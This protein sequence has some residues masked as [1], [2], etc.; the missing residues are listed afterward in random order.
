[1]MSISRW[2]EA[3]RKVIAE[4]LQEHGMKCYAEYKKALHDA[5]P[6]GMRQYHPYK[7]WCQE[8]K[9]AL[10]MH[11]ECPLHEDIYETPL[12]DWAWLEEKE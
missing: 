6:F 3:S 8:Q 12:L 4:V 10:M 2:R 9:K 7:I 1:M 11:P 5:Y